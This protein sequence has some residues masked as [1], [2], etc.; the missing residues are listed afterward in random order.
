M[1]DGCIMSSEFEAVGEGMRALPLL[2]L[3]DLIVEM[4]PMMVDLPF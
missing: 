4:T 1:S 3:A 2:A